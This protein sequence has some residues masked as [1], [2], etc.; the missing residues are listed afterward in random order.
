MTAEIAIQQ[1]LNRYSVG[2]S[3]SDWD[4][5]LATFVP[6]AVWEVPVHKVKFTG[7]AEIRQG[8]IRFSTGYDYMLQV[9]APAVITVSGD[10][11]MA[12]SVIREGGKAT[13]RDES[14]EV[15]GIYDDHLIRTTEGWRFTRRLFILRGMFSYPLNPPLQ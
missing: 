3:Q 14:L 12:K 11:A 2:A 5:V 6:D 4:M 1:T 15:H 10:T 8:L 13:G 7:Y 9:N